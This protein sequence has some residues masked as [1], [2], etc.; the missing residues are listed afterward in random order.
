V[1]AKALYVVTRVFWLLVKRL[2]GADIV[3]LGGF[4]SILGG[5]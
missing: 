4:Q 2:L 5:C 1:V 3:V